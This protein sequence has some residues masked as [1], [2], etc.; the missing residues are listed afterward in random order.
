MYKKNRVAVIIMFIFV[1]LLEVAA[2]ITYLDILRLK[3][4]G[5]LDALGIIVLLPIYIGCCVIMLI[6]SV[7]ISANCGEIKNKAKVAN[8]P[9]PV[10]D[11]IFMI[12]SWVLLAVSV[13][14]FVLIWI[15]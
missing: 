8:I 14:A 3:T 13:I 10:A 4:I 2:L 1:C 6:L 5:T 12:I 9:V 7:F 11:K 15:I